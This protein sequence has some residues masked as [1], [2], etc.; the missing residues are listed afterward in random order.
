[1]RS[2]RRR[3]RPEAAEE[4]LVRLVVGLAP[5]AGRRRDRVKG[6]V[7]QPREV[8]LAGGA[9][10]DMGFDAVTLGAAEPFGQQPF[11]HAG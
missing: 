3:H 2:A 5:A 8:F 6:P 7:A 11:E 4:G 10:F 9:A 1:M